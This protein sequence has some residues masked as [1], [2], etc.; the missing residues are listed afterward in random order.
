MTR[1]EKARFAR[2]VQRVNKDRK[3]DRMK[4][5]IQH[6]T[7]TTF[8]HCVS[9]AKMSYRIN[10]RFRLGADEEALVRG[11]LLHDYYLYDWHHWESAVK[12]GALHGLF[13]PGEALKNAKCDFDLNKKEENI[14]YS[15]MWPL[16]PLQIPKCREAVIVCMADKICSAKETLLQRKAK[17][18]SAKKENAGGKAGKTD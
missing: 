10:R 17:Q 7:V 6:G 1:S 4:A 13:H 3:L 16:T 5:F 14:I 11:A 12:K 18:R 2:M 9:V 15:H 8:D